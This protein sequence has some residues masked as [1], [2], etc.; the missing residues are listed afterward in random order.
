MNRRLLFLDR[1]LGTLLGLALI[2]LA[3]LAVDWRYQVLGSF[4]DTLSLSQVQTAVASGWWP[5]AFAGVALL[6]GI[7]ALLWLTAHL[8]RRGPSS[9]RL[10][11][12][13]ETGSVDADL[14]SVAGAAAHQLGENAPLV[15]VRGTVRT[16]G[17]GRTLIELRGHVDPSADTDD[18]STAV[19][20]M[21][22]QVREAFPDGSVTCRVLVH[23][24]TSARNR[25]ST[26]VQ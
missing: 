19:R 24:P 5:W 7:L 11:S 22:A 23:A 12:S 10:G 26:R 18:L 4:P 25:R 8:G 1:T 3:L 14:R 16:I 21:S 15:G 6:L 17:R 13:N 2:A 9:L 20:T